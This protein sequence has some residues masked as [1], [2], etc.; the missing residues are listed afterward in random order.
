MVTQLQFTFPSPAAI[1]W[2]Y[3]QITPAQMAAAIVGMMYAGW[4]WEH[5]GRDWQWKNEATGYTMTGAAAA[6]MWTY[7]DINQ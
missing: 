6:Y 4:T 3:F 1:T 7:E 2:A 5:V